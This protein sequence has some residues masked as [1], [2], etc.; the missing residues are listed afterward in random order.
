[1]V[2]LRIRIARAGAP[3]RALPILRV[4]RGRGQIIQPVAVR[5]GGAPLPLLPFSH[6]IVRRDPSSSRRSI[7]KGAIWLPLSETAAPPASEPFACWQTVKRLDTSELRRRTAPG[8]ATT[9]PSF[10]RLRPPPSP[11]L[12]C[13]PPIRWVDRSET[14]RR[15]NA[16][17]VWWPGAAIVPG[18]NVNEG[19]T[20]QY[21]TE[22]NPP[23]Q[24]GTELYLSWDSDAPPG[25]VFQ[26][27]ENDQLVWTGSSTYCTLPLPQHLV[28]FDIGTVGFTQRNT[29][30]ASLLPPAPLLQAELTWLGGTFE[31]SDIAGFHIYGEETAGSGI[32]YTDI[33][34]TIPAYTAGVIT[35]GFGY[36]GFGQGGFGAAPGSY[37]WTSDALSSGTWHFAVVPFDTSGNEGA[38]AT[39]SVVIVAPP[40]EPAPF[41]DR[42]RLH[43]SWNATTD[44]VTLSWNA[45]PG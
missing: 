19:W 40:G 22:V 17:R 44:E 32:D 42:T 29:S 11:P 39:T 41:A 16:G 5:I 26:V 2:F 21:I 14:L 3:L 13:G 43:Y 20:Q 15:V 30:F 23:V 27:Y 31:G 36:G 34:A 37:S 4:A 25:L 10:A 38:G 6:G 8:R 28:R 12:A 18:S 33:L 7:D 24:Y 35:D 9:P 1:M 45:S